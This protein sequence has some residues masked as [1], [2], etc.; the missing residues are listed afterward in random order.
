MKL[1]E[2]KEEDILI[3]KQTKQEINEAKKFN[4]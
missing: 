4:L 2:S 3:I 1:M